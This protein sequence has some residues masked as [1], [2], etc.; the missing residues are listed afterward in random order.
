M[1]QLSLP[2]LCRVIT[3]SKD[4][5]SAGDFAAIREAAIQDSPC[6]VLLDFSEVERFT[7]D[8][9]LA[10]MVMDKLLYE[11]GCKLFLCA[12]PLRITCVFTQLGVETLFVFTKDTAQALAAMHYAA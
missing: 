2:G 7:Y 10:L 3:M 12:V 9:V 5:Q 8:G 1:G 4:P 11:N 6:N